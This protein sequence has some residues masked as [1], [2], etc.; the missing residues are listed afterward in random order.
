VPQKMKAALDDGTGKYELHEVSMP[1][2]FEGAAMIRVRQT[3]I[4]GS[5]LHMTNSRTEAQILPS[6]HEVA[7]EIVELPAG[8]MRL[9]VGDRVALETIGAGRACLRCHYCRFGQYRHC[10]NLAP[11]TGGGFAEYMTRTPTGLFKLPDSIDWVDGALV[12][13]MAVSV[14][15]LR[16][17]G[18]KPGDVIG[19]TGAATI[20]LSAIAAAHAFGAKKVIAS[21][22]YP[23]QRSAALKM[24]A[25]VVTGV[26]DGEFEDACRA[27]SGG[28]GADIVL[29]SVGGHQ[30]AALHQAIRSTRPQGKVVNLGGIKVPMEID[31]FDPLL[32]EIAVISVSCYD[33]IEGIHDYE[34]AIDLLASGKVP[35]RE[36][37]T[38]KYSLDDIK[39]GFATAYDKNSG[40]IKVHI[41]Q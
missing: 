21:A 37:V 20:G 31:L 23:H 4:C 26:A 2:M 29:E 30:T 41:T 33:V 40:S 7:G 24:G 17:A 5:D 18:M 16:Y 32:R 14:H 34:V 25:D 10:R 39:K 6:G 3:G 1:K 12:E 22:K 15:A 11:D 13:P 36:I 38:H 28:L 8:E 27:A 19:V 9:K 35:Y